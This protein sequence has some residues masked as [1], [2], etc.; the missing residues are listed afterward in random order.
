MAGFM[1]AIHFFGFTH[2]RLSAADVLFSLPANCPP[3]DSS[4][5]PR[6]SSKYFMRSYTDYKVRHLDAEFLEI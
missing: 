3:F 6:R 1:P 4:P 2:Q 5:T